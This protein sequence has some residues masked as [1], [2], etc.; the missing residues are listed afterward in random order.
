MHIK[1]IHNTVA[2]AISRLDF[3]MVK[4]DKDNWMPFMKCWCHYTMHAPNS[5]KPYDH[6]ISRLTI[7]KVECR[8][9]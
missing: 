3:G 5:E 6:D 7:K 1:G 2:D 4:D 8:K 9:S